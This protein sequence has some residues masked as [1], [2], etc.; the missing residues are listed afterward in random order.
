MSVYCDNL[1]D[2]ATVIT[3]LA[4][5]SSPFM[6]PFI[7]ELSDDS[8]SVLLF[9]AISVTAAIFYAKLTAVDTK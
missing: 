8:E 5:T 7:T 2:L 3:F 4:M 1:E 6:I 9:D